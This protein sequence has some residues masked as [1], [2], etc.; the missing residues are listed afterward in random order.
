LF[1]TDSNRYAVAS[2]CKKAQ[3]ITSRA[4]SS[5]RLGF[6]VKSFSTSEAAQYYRNTTKSISL[7]IKGLCGFLAAF[8]CFARQETAVQNIKIANLNERVVVV[9]SGCLAIKNTVEK[10]RLKASGEKV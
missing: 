2:Y 7:K 9:F 6:S 1:A 5:L 3:I 8:P 4:R 10:G